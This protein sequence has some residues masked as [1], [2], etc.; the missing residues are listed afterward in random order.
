MWNQ[1]QQDHNNNP[2]VNP[3]EC[4]TTETGDIICPTD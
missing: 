2:A 4:R 3:R 1:S